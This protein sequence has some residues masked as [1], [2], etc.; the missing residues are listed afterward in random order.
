MSYTKPIYTDIHSRSTHCPNVLV[1][2]THSLVYLQ[3]HVPRGLEDLV[4]ITYY[5]TYLPCSVISFPCYYWCWQYMYII[6]HL[7]VKAN[8]M[9]QRF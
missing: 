9:R 2:L 6:A 8:I 1:P 5:T 7:G 4:D 3:L